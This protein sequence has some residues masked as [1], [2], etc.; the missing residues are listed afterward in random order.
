MEILRGIAASPGVAIGKAFVLD[1]EWFRI[2]QRLVEPEQGPAEVQRVRQA[3]A[4]AARETRD[5]QHQV[6]ARLGAQYGAIFGAHAL[7][8]TDPALVREIEDLILQSRYAAEYA[9]SR[10]LR[11]YVKA[12]EGLGSETLSARV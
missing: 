3:L 6:S 4:D 12:L 8:L 10:V 7:L 1:T 11:R 9:T 2:R 5:S